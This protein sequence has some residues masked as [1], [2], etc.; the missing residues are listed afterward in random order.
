MWGVSAAFDGGLISLGG[1]QGEMGSV[2][3]K[4]IRYD[5]TL[6]RFSV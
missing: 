4:S 3:V 1:Q 2:R 5:R 6:L